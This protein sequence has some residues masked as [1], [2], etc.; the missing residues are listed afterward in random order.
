MKIIVVGAGGTIGSAIVDVLEM[1]HEVLKASRKG[2][3]PVDLNEPDS[4]I[5]MYARNPGVDAVISAAGEARFGRLDVFSDMDFELSLRNKLLGQINLVRFGREF[6]NDGGVFILTT[7][8]LAHHAPPETFMPAVVN[9]ALEAF[10]ETAA[11]DMPRNQRLNAVCPP[12]AR[13]TA[14]RMGLGRR[15]MP[16]ADIAVFYIQSLES[17]L[18]GAVIGPEHSH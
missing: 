3:I 2:P 18:N 1:N 11:L 8:V 7:G 9:R 17:S 10:V 6:L 14:A 16:A 12:L 4:I 13:E 5:E 15:G